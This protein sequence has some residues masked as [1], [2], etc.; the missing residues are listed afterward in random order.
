MIACSRQRSC[1]EEVLNYHQ[2][3]VAAAAL[4]SNS[5]EQITDAFERAAIKPSTSFEKRYYRKAKEQLKIIDTMQFHGHFKPIGITIFA[6]RFSGMA[7][8]KILVHDTSFEETG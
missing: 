5:F 8:W 6:A 7:Y 3:A 1:L 2:H 4:G